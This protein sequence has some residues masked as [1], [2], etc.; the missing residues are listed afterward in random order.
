MLVIEID[1]VES[2]GTVR[3]CTKVSA[4]HISN[5]TLARQNEGCFFSSYQYT[6]TPRSRKGTRK[7]RQ[8]GTRPTSN[9]D[10]TKAQPGFDIQHVLDPVLRRE[11]NGVRDETVFVSKCEKN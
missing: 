9:R 3:F 6:T 1:K 8:L 5:D 7:K 4:N 10:T 2:E 11:N